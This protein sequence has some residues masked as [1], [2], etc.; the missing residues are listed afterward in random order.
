MLTL[1]LSFKF[2]FVY[3]RLSHSNYNSISNESYFQMLTL[4]CT[5]FKIFTVYNY[6]QTV[7]V[8]V[9]MG[10]QPKK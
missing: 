5:I 9:K 10:V 2:Y 1:I 3:L 7:H 4:P 8:Y 6:L